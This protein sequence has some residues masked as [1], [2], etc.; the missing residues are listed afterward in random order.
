MKPVKILGLTR[1]SPMGASSRVRSYQY[2]PFLTEAGFTVQWAPL[3]DQ[4][5]LEQLYTTRSRSTLKL[6]N[7]YMQRLITLVTSKDIDL[8]WMEKE[9]WPWVPAWFESIFIGLKRPLVVDYDDAI[10]HNYDTHPNP[11]VRAIWGNKIDAVMKRATVVTAG[12]AYLAQRANAAGAQRVEILPSVVDATE[13][14]PRLFD[15]GSGYS[16]GWIG[17]PASQVLLEPLYGL[18]AEG[19]SDAGD[20]FVTIGAKFVEPLFAS[21]QI[22]S[23]SKATEA[24]EVARFDVGIMPVTDAPF[25]RGKCGYKLIQ[26]MASGVPVIASPV[27]VNTEIV[28]HGE[29]GFLASTPAEWRTAIATLKSNPQLRQEMGRAGRARFEQQY[30]LEVV[31][32]RLISI[33]RSVL[34]QKSG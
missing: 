1:H 5:Y 23:W 10:F 12:N 31:A 18:L 6:I 22:M 27:G 29:T 17:S 32:P 16:V 11:L 8:I 26:Y 3:L 2:E 7:R 34:E 20:R 9:C 4:A 15:S 33:F 14:Q 30:S 13:Y 28:R 19:L 25:E 21:H 24:T